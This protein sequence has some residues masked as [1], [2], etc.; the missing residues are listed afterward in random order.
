[1]RSVG[2]GTFYSSYTEYPNTTSLEF[3]TEA[4]ADQ[5]FVNTKGECVQ[6][7]EVL[8]A[9]LSGSPSIIGTLS[10]VKGD[11]HQLLLTAGAVYNGPVFT[12]DTKSL[13][14][15]EGVDWSSSDS[16]IAAVSEAGIVKAGKCGEAS[17]TAKA[18]NGAAAT[19]SFGVDHVLQKIPAVEAT[20]TKT[21][22][23][24]GEK[25]ANCGEVTKAQQVV[26]VKD[27]TW[28]SWKTVKEATCTGKGSREK[29]C[30]FCGEK[31]TKAIPA[32]GHEWNSYYTIDREPTFTREGSRSKHCA[33]C[34]VSDPDSVQSI[35]KLKASWK[36]DSKGWW[37]D[38]GDGTYPAGKFETIEGRTFYF[39][40][41]GYMAM[42]WRQ[43]GGKWYFFGENGAMRTGWQKIG[44]R[45]CYFNSKGAM[46]TGW[47]KI[48]GKWYYFAV[49]GAM[50]TGWQKIS[51]KWYYFAAGGA[52]EANKWVGSYYLGAGGA[53]ATNTWIG[54]YYVGADGKW[55]PG[56]GTRSTS[57]G[58][59]S[60][61]FN[62]IVYWVSGGSVYHR[63]KDCPSLARSSNIKQGTIE[64]SGKSEACHNCFH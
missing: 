47:Q 22:L 30:T 9:R 50:Q 3:S 63:S 13:L 8:E 62:G 29:T 53:M 51:D 19:A 11:A 35:P 15:K 42:G 43:I 61:T 25:C 18:E 26:P 17:I 60:S 49:G 36:R 24:E 41:S 45:W 4:G 2:A 54:K 21:G 33:V 46:Q 58:N 52:M 39:S 12:A 32:N 16:G 56:Y 28:S 23:S 14:F 20:C 34:G 55:I 44:V 64:E 31:V 37:Y 59:S 6:K 48:G 7:L 5:S 1:M 10:G 57:G 38:Y 27:H 40:T